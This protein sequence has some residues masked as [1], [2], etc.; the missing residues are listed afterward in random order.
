LKG[1]AVWQVL[2]EQ[3]SVLDYFIDGLDNGVGE[4]NITE[5]AQ[6]VDRYKAF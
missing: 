3:V 1:I 4:V 5:S 6:L 2:W